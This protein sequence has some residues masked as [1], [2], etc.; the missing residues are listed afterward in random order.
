MKCENCDGNGGWDIP[1]PCSPEN[2][3]WIDDG[4]CMELGYKK[5]FF[6]NGS[7]EISKERLNEVK[8]IKRKNKTW[9]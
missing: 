3:M 9:D 7:G 1:V 2:T 6:C 5:C 4:D 8:K